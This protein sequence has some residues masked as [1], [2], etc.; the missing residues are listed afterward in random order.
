MASGAKTAAKTIRYFGSVRKTITMD[1]GAETQNGF[2]SDSPCNV[3]F[4]PMH[5]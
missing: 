3:R 1:T 5:T 4:M 2:A